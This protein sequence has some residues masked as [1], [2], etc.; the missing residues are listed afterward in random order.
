MKQKVIFPEYMR[1]YDVLVC[2]Y[3]ECNATP[4]MVSAF[5]VFRRYHRERE[6]VF[7]VGSKISI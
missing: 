4:P 2:L 5:G 6:R 3:L 7:F 1:I